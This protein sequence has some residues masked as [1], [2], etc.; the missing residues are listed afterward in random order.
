MSH[1]MYAPKQTHASTHTHAGI[2]IA[3]IILTHVQNKY[4][5]REKLWQTTI[6]LLQLYYI[7]YST[8]VTV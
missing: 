3:T 2:Q 1:R 6:T 7:S 8:V 5:I 4:N